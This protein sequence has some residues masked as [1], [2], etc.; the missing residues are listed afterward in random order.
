MSKSNKKHLLVHEITH[1]KSIQI[2]ENLLNYNSFLIPPIKIWSP[3]PPHETETL[4][5]GT[6]PAAV[7]CGSSSG[8]T[9]DCTEGAMVLTCNQVCSQISSEPLGES[10]PLDFITSKLFLRSS[11]TNSWIF[12]LL[13]PLN[14]TLV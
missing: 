6:T 14:L 12:P 13:F 9:S 2:Y 7:V 10:I 4:T 11:G 5:A 3:D 1:T 8:N